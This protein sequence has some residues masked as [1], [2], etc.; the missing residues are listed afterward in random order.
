[1]K[2]QSDSKDRSD[3]KHPLQF[4]VVPARVYKRWIFVS[5]LLT[6]ILS[7]FLFPLFRVSSIV[8]EGLSQ[9]SEFFM[10]HS[11]LKLLPSTNLFGEGEFLGNLNN[12]LS[13]FWGNEYESLGS[14][15]RILR[16]QGGRAKYPVVMIPGITSTGLE[17][18]QGRTCAQPYFRQRLWGTLTMMRF[19]LLD[20]SC[21]L[22]HLKLD[23]NS[24]GDPDGIKLR[25]AQGLEAADFILPGFWVWA[26]MIENLAEIGYDHNNLVMAAYDWRVGISQLEERDH[27]FSRLKAQIELLVRTRGEKVVILSHSL[28]GLIWFYFMKWVEHTHQAPNWIE[29]HIHASVGIGAPY[30]GVPKATS[31]IISGEMRDT[32]Q[33]GR[34]ESFLLEM[35]M[36]K[37]ERLSLFR[38]WVGGFAML[39]K[40]GNLFWGDGETAGTLVDVSDPGV[41]YGILNLDEQ[42]AEEA[43]MKTIYTTN[44]INE[45]MELFMPE[46]PLKRIRESY[47]FKDIAGPSQVVENDKLHQKW[48]NVLEARL[49]N[50]PSSK[51]YCFYGYGK[52]TER[53]YR[54]QVVPRDQWPEYLQGLEAKDLPKHQ[55]TDDLDNIL[56]RIK[57]DLEALD[58]S[59]KLYTGIYHVDGDG[60]V[61]VLSNG[62]M[63]A[64][65]WQKF[66]HLNPGG[67]K[68]IT[69]EYR[70][71]SLSGL[72]KLRG[73]PKTSDHVDILGNHEMTMDI[74]KIVSDWGVVEERIETDVINMAKKI[75]LPFE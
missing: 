23:P 64:Y 28:G 17:L 65:G 21:W 56:L 14:P 73:G 37:R 38:T 15:G 40:G 36:S 6:F 59:K 66:K 69:R 72:A 26:R 51:I 27:Y 19:M 22:E 60:T 8:P 11:L 71:E 13:P 57:L 5:I 47:S 74:L 55:R 48:T 2:H 31:M 9:L 35:L 44:D 24:G 41:T 3:G 20:S 45:L 54:Y 32:A 10:E 30:L 18:W 75:K 7:W 61:P 25:P 49:P 70:D 68:V 52:D 33:M 53:G 1:M 29:E 4:Q 50:A 42:D 12:I 62:Y 43:Q 58:P 67:M 46:G 34:L 39:P 16:E 63:C